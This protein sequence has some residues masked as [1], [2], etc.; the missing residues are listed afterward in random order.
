MANDKK[1]QK[2]SKKSIFKKKLE[3][4]FNIRDFFKSRLFPIKHLDKIETCQAK[5]KRATE[6]V[7]ETKPA[8]GKKIKN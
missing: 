1:V 6:T 5:P 7:V 2:H 3:L 4:L 8:K